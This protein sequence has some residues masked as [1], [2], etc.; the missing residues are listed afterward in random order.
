MGILLDGVDDLFSVSDNSDF[1]VGSGDFAISF[2][3]KGPITGAN[4]A[5]IQL[6][7][8]TG[9]H[10]AIIGY[11][12][13]TDFRMFLSSN[14]STFDIASNTTMGQRPTSGVV[15]NYMLMRSGNTFTTYKGTAQTNTFTNS[16]SIFHTP[17]PLQIGRDFAG[18]AAQFS[19]NGLIE[20]LFVWKGV[21]LSSIEREI[22]VNSN[23]KNIELQIQPANIVAGWGFCGGP[24]GDSADGDVLIDLTGNG[25]DAIGDDG[26]NNSGLTWKAEDI[27]S[28]PVSPVFIN[29]SIGGN[30]G[31][32]LNAGLLGGKLQHR[33]IG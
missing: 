7:A 2:R 25:N 28:Y 26:A 12:A 13:G 16:S 11:V 24:D 30:S 33:L 29:T 23:I 6:S 14:G 31:A 18:G 27:L 9:G 15:E 1:D 21:S 3:V 5:V 32:L 4:G 8:E 22:I 17:A 10:G 19:I 20:G